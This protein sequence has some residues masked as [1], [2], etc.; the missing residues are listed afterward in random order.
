[1]MSMPFPLRPGEPDCRDYLRTGRCK[2]GESCKYNHPTNVENGGG[3]KPTNPGEPLFPIR[4]M[5]PTCQYFLKHGTCKF[6]QACKFNHPSGSS[7]ADG[8]GGI[9]GGQLVFVTSN[10][11]VPG[12][13]ITGDASSL[14]AA[15]TSIQVLPQ[16][17]TEPNC[18]YFLRNGKCK[19]GATCKF[20]H[21][22]DA[23]NNKNS[24]NNIRRDRS[25]SAGS[26]SDNNRVQQIQQQQQITY[27]HAAANVTYVQQQQPQRLQPITERRSHQQATHILLPDGQIAVILDP[28]SLQ[29]VSE[30]NAQ[31]R[32]KF[33][34][35]QTD[36]SMG[37]LRSI[38]QQ[39]N[40]N[41]QQ[42]HCMV[43]PML[44]ATTAA[45]NST[46]NLTFDSNISDLVGTNVSYQG[47][48]QEMQS[49]GGGP[50][51]SGSGGSLSA[52][53]SDS[54]YP[55]QHN[56]VSSQVPLHQQ[57]PT[58]NNNMPSFP[59]YSAW[60]LSEGLMQPSSSNQPSS[61]EQAPRGSQSNPEA[62][63]RQQQ[64]HVGNLEIAAEDSA[65]YYWPSSGSFSSIQ[66]QQQAGRNYLPNSSSPYGS[67]NAVGS[68]RR[69]P[70]ISPSS[71]G[72]RINHGGTPEN[73]RQESDEGLSM[74]T[75]ALLTMIDHRDSPSGENESH[76]QPRRSPNQSSLARRVVHQNTSQSEPNLRDER[77]YPM[78]PP[79]GMMCPPGMSNNIESSSSN[80]GHQNLANAGSS[81]GY[82]VGGYDQPAPNSSPPWGRR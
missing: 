9:P 18:M 77:S 3:V 20:H 43:S 47:H 25:H 54:D 5:E 12:G 30:L 39:N 28:K 33:Y 71:S 19:Y 74:M 78:R 36:G 46:S 31:D 32:P 81:G 2:Y 22:L 72:E 13:A 68:D 42:Q 59:Q 27:A 41:Q 61:Q 4:P 35:S 69:R 8:S 80:Y 15:S 51:R 76:G 65:A 45:T 40:N 64:R 48:F 79:P 60:P 73:N 14:M 17:P 23:I 56:I 37:N 29:N 75:S 62:L 7:L 50:H 53:G 6:G 16:R 10:N 34:L 26:S 52:Y 63:D 66:Q 1:M 38:D 44:T 82:F 24:N 57:M 21:P 67:R 70:S 11:G 58:N 49:R 55:S